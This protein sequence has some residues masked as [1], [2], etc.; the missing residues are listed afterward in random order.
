VEPDTILLRQN[1]ASLNECQMA[2]S[3]HSDESAFLRAKLSAFKLKMNVAKSKTAC[4]IDAIAE[5]MASWCHLCDH[6]AESL[7]RG[8]TQEFEQLFA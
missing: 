7:E 5:H 8:S 1:V 2:K 6:A 4:V 3:K